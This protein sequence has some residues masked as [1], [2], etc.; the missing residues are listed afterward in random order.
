MCYYN[1]WGRGCGCRRWN[2]CNG[3]VGP[4]GIPGPRGPAGPAGPAGTS[5]LSAFNNATATIATTVAIPL[6]TVANLNTANV[7]HTDGTAPVTLGAGTYLVTYGANA[8]S[9]T[10]GAVEL[11][12]QVA[13]TTVDTLG[14]TLTTAGDITNLSGQVAITVPAG[15]TV[16]LVNSGANETTYSN[17]DL[18]VQ[19]VS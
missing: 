8:T 2:Y 13:G 17:V 16:Q 10:A 14:A 6:T 12:L 9:A 15:T 4:Q 7:V 19:Q 5:L 3:L 1:N 11:S 18:V